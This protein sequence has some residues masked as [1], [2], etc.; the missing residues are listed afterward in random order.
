M[1]KKFWKGLL[2]V[3]ITMHILAAMLMP[4]GLDAHV[5]ASYVSD[6]MDDD[7]AH[8]EWGPL[9]PDS[10][11]KS[12]PR[13]I[14]ADDKWFAWHLIIEIWFTIFS[15]SASTLHVLGLIG[16]LGCLAA[17][18]LLTK[19]LFGHEQALRLTALASV[20]QPL[21]RATG[22]FYQE[23]IILMLVAF[24][25]YCIIK[26]LRSEK[27]VNWWLA[28][29][30]FCAL[31]I[32]SF[33]GMPLWYVI[34]AGL[35]LLASTRMQMNVIQ[36]AAVS[37]IV[38]LAVLYRNGI[39]ITHIDII[40]ALL[41]GY[42][43]Y[44]LFVI[45]GIYYFTQQDGDENEES[46]I[47]HRGSLMIA[48]CLVGWIAALWMTENVALEKEFFDT[49]QSLSQVPRYLSL[50]LVPLWFARMLRDNSS[51]LSLSLNRS[52]VVVAVSIMLL[53]NAYILSGSGPRGTDV[54]GE[55]I[56]NEI[57]DGEDVLFLAS[58]PL[59]MHRLYTIKFSMDPDS[60]GDHTGF[61]R[62]KNS[63]WE[64]ELAQCDLFK[65]IEWIVVYPW[66]DPIIPE[67]W[68]KTDFEGSDLVSDSYELY[69]W[70]EEYERCP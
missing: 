57:E 52:A 16:G 23:G 60:D 6:G 4:L 44:F 24:A 70:G 22:R 11:E 3:G 7:E 17:I 53:L 10:P 50:L 20:Y 30:I 32:L 8:L 39:S 61:W 14:P 34:P 31:I 15:P 69:A 67:G 59:S 5:H 64:A 28:P 49:V 46:R 21:M 54:I 45:G 27:V 47:I 38:Q 19:D 12:T 58:S 43:A 26:A 62:S 1:E 36:V 66:I 56:G 29:P 55:H 37:L 63:G 68:V 25:T 9:R 48:G 35:A 51:G 33:K 41:S 18:Y 2:L 40:P 13:E 65:D 42:V